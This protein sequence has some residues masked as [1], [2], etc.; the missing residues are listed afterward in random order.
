MVALPIC[1]VA[2]VP[3]DSPAASSTFQARHARAP[4]GNR[5][6][7]PQ[8]ISARVWPLLKLPGPACSSRSRSCLQG[9][10]RPWTA[11]VRGAAD[12]LEREAKAVRY[13]R[14]TIVPAGE[15]LLC[16]FEGI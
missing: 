2:A 1:G 4:T 6:Q 9:R 5:P 7:L 10:G 13:L 16:L 8:A 12:D 3:G 14:A 15:S 11:R